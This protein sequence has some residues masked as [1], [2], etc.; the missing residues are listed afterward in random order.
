MKGRELFVIGLV[1][2]AL[3]G[4]P[5]LDQLMI[6]TGEEGYLLVNDY[7]SGQK[8][9]WQIT[10]AQDPAG[11]CS[12]QFFGAPPTGSLSIGTHEFS[13]FVVLPDGTHT[14]WGGN[15]N[16]N[17]CSVANQFSGSALLLV[18]NGIGVSATDPTDYKGKNYRATF[19]AS[20]NGG[21]ASVG[22]QGCDVGLDIGQRTDY[23]IISGDLNPD[24]IIVRKNGQTVCNTV[25]TGPLHV[26]VGVGGNDAKQVVDGLYIVQDRFQPKILPACTLSPGDLLA[27]ETFQAG[28][29][30]DFFSTR[31]PTK[32]YCINSPAIITDVAAGGVSSTSEIYFVL[33]QGQTFTIPDGQTMTL[34]YTFDNSEG[35]V[36]QQCDVATEVYSV[37][38]SACL[39]ASGIVQVCSSGIFDPAQG[40]C[41]VESVPTCDQGRLE[42]VDGEFTCV[43]NPPVNQECETGTL[44]PETGQCTVPASGCPSGFE[45]EVLPSGALKCTAPL[46][47]EEV[48]VVPGS[49]P[50]SQQRGFAPSI[51]T[52]TTAALPSSS[53]GGQTGLFGL[54]N[55]TIIIVILAAIAAFLFGRQRKK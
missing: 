50:T 49:V 43:F 5:G 44:D 11:A 17:V 10:C 28:D 39:P 19:Y 4:A 52:S 53:I 42:V 8:G 22:V 34:F 41:V 32:S 47:L 1:V 54:S 13:G 38:Q 40:V 24:E 15:C 36:P 14:Y 18:S 7:N 26:T 29:T 16:E 33:Q 23:E 30:I 37:D 25:N 27:A 48:A 3:L 46:T 21:S 45:E 51:T 2:W 31:F 20:G 55:T 6:L 12:R 35:L 9:T